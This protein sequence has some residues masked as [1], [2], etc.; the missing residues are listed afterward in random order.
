MRKAPPG[1]QQTSFDVKVEAKN[2]QKI[3]RNI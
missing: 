2:I 3:L 1:K